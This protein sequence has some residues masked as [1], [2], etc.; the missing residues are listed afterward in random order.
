MGALETTLHLLIPNFFY[1]VDVEK[2]GPMSVT[3]AETIIK[4][5][6]NQ[7]D[8]KY[9]HHSTV[10]WKL[11]LQNDG[12]YIIIPVFHCRLTYHPPSFTPSLTWSL[13]LA[14]LW[15]V[16]DDDSEDSDYAPDL[17][18]DQDE[19]HLQPNQNCPSE[20][21]SEPELEQAQEE[22]PDLSHPTDVQSISPAHQVQQPTH[23]PSQEFPIAPKRRTKKGT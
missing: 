11:D 22:Q 12:Q 1:S 3:D 18:N 2:F 10:S 9:N 16:L 8:C 7:I 4:L 17:E 5:I 13:S 14:L 20:P 19:E 15:C 6:E 21:E 23:P